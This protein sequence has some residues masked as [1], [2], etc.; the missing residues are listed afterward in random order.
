ML[1]ASCGAHEAVYHAAEMFGLEF[2]QLKGGINA[3]LPV[4]D[5][6]GILRS[7]MDRDHPAIVVATLGNRRGG[8]DDIDSIQEV[9]AIH[10]ASSKGQTFLHVDAARTF[11]FLTTLPRKRRLQ[12]GLPRLLLRA[13]PTDSHKSPGIVHASTIVAGGLNFSN[14]PFVVALKPRCL[15]GG[16]GRYIECVQGPDSTLSGSR[17]ALNGLLVA[18]QEKRFQRSGIRQIYARCRRLRNMLSSLL[19]EK[20]VQ[21]DAPNS[22]LDLIVTLSTSPHKDQQA[23]LGLMDLGGGRFLMTVQPSVT[24]THIH[25]F[26]EDIL[27]MEC[28]PRTIESL[29]IDLNAYKVS[30]EVEDKL[31]R[32]AAGWQVK[33]RSSGGYHGNHSTL[34]ALGP[35][36]GCMLTKAIPINWVL[37]QKRNL[38]SDLKRRLGVPLEKFSDFSGGITT[39]GSM[40]NRV[41][42]LTALKHYPDGHVYLSTATHYSVRKILENRFR[43]SKERCSRFS[44]VETDE[45]GRMIPESFAQRVLFDR[46]LA[47]QRGQPH[48]IILLANFG[49]TFTGGSDDVLG[50][51]Q[52]VEQKGLAIDHIHA[53]GALR[54][55][56]D[57]GC[58]RL[59]PPR[60]H[61][62][63]KPVVQSISISNHKF[64]G[65]S[66]SGLV[67]CYVPSGGSLSTMDS[68]SDPRIAFEVWLYNQLFSL[69][70]VAALHR[71]CISNAQ[72]LRSQLQK[73]GIITRF[74]EESL[75]TLVERQPLRLVEKFD[76]SPK[77]NWIHFITMPHITRECIDSFVSSV[78]AHRDLFDCALASA[79]ESLGVTI[80]KAKTPLRLKRIACCEDVFITKCMSLLPTEYAEDFRRLWVRHAMSFA[81]VNEIGDPV[82]IFLVTVKPG[83]VIFLD[84]VMLGVGA[85]LPSAVELGNQVMAKLASVLDYTFGQSDSFPPF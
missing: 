11:D 25:S 66:V 27:G 78:S 67:L 14:P 49:T 36:I 1:I 59:G 84:R 77:E 53:D 85:S 63:S 52:S 42:L 76:L 31:C 45:M 69:D 28:V 56:Y 61:H 62:A 70:D 9:L 60:S 47:L 6:D 17:D 22:S 71:G 23:R 41:G 39:G 80:G 16:P 40:G 32:M 19:E 72:H 81:A 29:D 64:A 35:I 24:A 5:L 4:S 33:S 82:I 34:S 10:R 37:A 30:K 7:R 58:I 75:I 26:V 55:G 74:N 48:Q 20:G 38:L 46:K 8:A 44:E 73:A 83:C 50:L 2:V 12:L 15:G 68:C 18:L 43:V 51:V 57:V 21:F 13:V 65:L 3:E 54:F 79:A